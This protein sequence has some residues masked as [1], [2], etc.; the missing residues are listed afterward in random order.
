M[1]NIIGYQ[2]ESNDGLHE[3]P[4]CFYSFEILSTIELAEL[5]LKHE[6]ITSE[7]GNFRWVI[8]PV[9]ENIIENPTFIDYI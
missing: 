9:F 6:A 1:E 5:W 8:V 2:I 4:E 3:I 7:N